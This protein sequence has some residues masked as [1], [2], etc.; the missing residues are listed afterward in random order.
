MYQNTGPNGFYGYNGNGISG[1]GTYYTDPGDFSG[2][3]FVGVAGDD[4]GSWDRS[5]YGAFAAQAYGFRVKSQDCTNSQTSQTSSNV[6]WVTFFIK[7]STSTIR[8]GNAT[9]GFQ[10]TSVG[11]A[12]TYYGW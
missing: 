6:G 2:A 3:G 9:D 8:W 12:W 7:S 1:V 5:G 10:G 4:D 11:S